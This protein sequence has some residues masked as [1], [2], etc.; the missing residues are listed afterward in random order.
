MKKKICLKCGK[1]YNVDEWVSCP[2]CDKE[3][4][5]RLK[6][7]PIPKPMEYWQPNTPYPNT[8]WKPSR[9]GPVWYSTNLY[10]PEYINGLL[11]SW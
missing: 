4:Y 1:P 5:E 10:T 6:K 2:T 3:E 7:L 8:P 11:V 9:F